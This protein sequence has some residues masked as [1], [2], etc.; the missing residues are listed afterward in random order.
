MNILPLRTQLSE[1]E[2]FRT[3]LTRVRRTV[4]DAFAHGEVPFEKIMEALPPRLGEPLFATWFGPIDS[5]QPFRMG[6]V[7]VTPQ[8][9]F[10]PR[11]QFDLSCFVSEQ[12]DEVVCYF[13]HI[14]DALEQAQ[15][16]AM[17]QKLDAFVA[18]AIESPDSPVGALLETGGKDAAGTRRQDACA[19]APVNG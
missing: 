12:P 14:R 2:S 16:T 18:R 5:L 4:L 11:A 1:T 10:P 8:I 9:L 15:V 7:Q 3:A 13:E 19:T 17:V 6:G